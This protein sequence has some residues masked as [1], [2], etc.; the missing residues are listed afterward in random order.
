MWIPSS[1][2][3]TRI[4]GVKLKRLPA[5]LSLFFKQLI[6]CWTTT[7]F[8]VFNFI[9]ALLQFL[10]ICFFFFI[11][12]FLTYIVNILQIFIVFYI[13]AIVHIF[14]FHISSVH[15]LLLYFLAPHA[16]T[17]QLPASRQL[18]HSRSPLYMFLKPS[19]SFPDPFHSHSH[20]IC[21]ASNQK[22]F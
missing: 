17:S 16:S 14:R 22:H 4:C 6:Y 20:Y 13:K 3:H 5:T 19:F 15:L 8:K 11:M 12:V 9:V 1:N 7:K 21:T 2:Q 18:L 10:F